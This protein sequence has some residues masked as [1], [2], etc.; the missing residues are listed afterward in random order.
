MS[1][2][3]ILC[4]LALVNCAVLAFIL[5]RHAKKAEW[6]AAHHSAFFAWRRSMNAKTAQLT[7]ASRHRMSRKDM[8]KRDCEYR[9][10]NRHFALASLLF[11]VLLVLYYLLEMP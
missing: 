5:R 11:L 4:L 7:S 2:L 6:W 9:F 1:F 3:D 10:V 8:I